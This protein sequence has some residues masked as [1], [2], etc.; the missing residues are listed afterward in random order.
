MAIPSAGAAEEGPAFFAIKIKENQGW[1]IRTHEAP[2][3]K[4]QHYRE[5]AARPRQVRLSQAMVH[6]GARME[7]TRVEGECEERMSSSDLGSTGETL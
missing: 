7:G 6:V 3:F 5:S 1:G 2:G 4:T